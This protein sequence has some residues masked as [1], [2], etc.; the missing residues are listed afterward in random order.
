[1]IKSLNKIMLLLS[2]IFLASCSLSAQKP[3][4]LLNLEE[5]NFSTTDRKLAT[6]A[7]SGNIKSI[8]VAIKQGANVNSI[9]TN[10]LPILFWPLRQQNFV[11]FESLL[12]KGGNPNYSWETGLSIVELTSGL[13]E[14]EFLK[15]V[16]KNNGNPNHINPVSKKSPLI[17]ATINDLQENISLLLDAGANIDYQDS[18]GESALFY[19]INLGQY[20]TAIFL[21]KEGADPKLKDIWG[22]T[23]GHSLNVR[24]DTP[25]IGQNGYESFVSLKEIFGHYLGVMCLFKSVRCLL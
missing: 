13:K 18:T 25:D 19:A 1:M 3:N 9:G 17:V 12:Q 7:G 5:L 10:G 21:L 20:D 24:L 16:L 2:M 22:N 11:G 23:A 6:A 15:T 8:N 4:L 14:K